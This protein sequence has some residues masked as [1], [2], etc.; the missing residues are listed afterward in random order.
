MENR[1]VSV[2][3]FQIENRWAE[4]KSDAIGGHTNILLFNVLQPA[5]IAIC[6]N[7]E[8]GARQATLPK[9]SRQ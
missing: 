7:V 5:I 3:L 9:S 6:T 1:C 4:L 8:A 2:R